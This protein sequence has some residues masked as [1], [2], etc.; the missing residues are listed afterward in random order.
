MARQ[1]G[2]GTSAWCVGEHIDLNRTP[3]GEGPCGIVHK[4]KGSGKD[5]GQHFAITTVNRNRI[6]QE[7]FEREIAHQRE[8]GHPNIA[9]IQEAFKDS[10]KLYIG[11]QLCTGK[12]LF[13]RI[14]E[15]AGKA[16]LTE[17]TVSGVMS[18]IISAMVYL[19]E[20]QYLHA[21][22][23]PD[24]LLFLSDAPDA[25]I[26]L[27]DFSLGTSCEPGARVEA[28]EPDVRRRREYYIAAGTPFFVAPE[29]LAGSFDHKCDVWSCGV[30]FYMLLCGYPPFCGHTEAET[31]NKIGIGNLEFPSADWESV[32]SI[33]KYLIRKMLDRN[34]HTRC[35][36]KACWAHTYATCSHG[37]VVSDI[38]PRLQQFAAESKQQKSARR[39]GVADGQNKA[40]KK[41]GAP[42]GRKRARA[43][44]L[45]FEPA[46]DRKE[47]ARASCE[48]GTRVR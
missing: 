40:E 46:S 22:V 18:Q 21:G 8:F 26:K 36:A 11:L 2:G 4:A 23:Q 15:D 48:G 7:H 44:Q 1:Y 3:L 42:R 13:E 25:P 31:L 38:V 19:H 39:G 43:S 20:R 5:K 45:E 27:I 41:A 37:E 33:A 34:P 14:V 9:S 17:T 30:I 35:E 16:P 32:S 29:V 6:L 28:A 10:Q 47:T 12:A 24:N